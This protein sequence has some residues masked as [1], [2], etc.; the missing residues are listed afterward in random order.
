MIRPFTTLRLGGGY[1]DEVG[2]KEAVVV[3]LDDVTDDDLLPCLL[4]P[5]PL[6]TQ[7]LDNRIVDLE[8]QIPLRLSTRGG[9]WGDRMYF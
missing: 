8:L 6:G 4:L 5:M 3:D 1:Y 9:A 2:G 7:H